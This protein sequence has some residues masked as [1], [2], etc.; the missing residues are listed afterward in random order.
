MLRH[1]I[2][3]IKDLGLTNGEFDNYQVMSTHFRE[4][5]ERESKFFRIEMPESENDFDETKKYD[6]PIFEIVIDDNDSELCLITK[7]LK[8]EEGV[9][10]EPL[11][12]S[13]FYLKI[14]QLEKEYSKYE[15]LASAWKNLDEKHICRFDRPII[16]VLVDQ[17]HKRVCM[18]EMG[19]EEYGNP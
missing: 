4:F 14:K 6:T 16:A 3:I 12:F 9:L 11:I 7:Y 15:V 18:V 17:E 13:N 5:N 10:R 1:L 19:P 2:K 8:E